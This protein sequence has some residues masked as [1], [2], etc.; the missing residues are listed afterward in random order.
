MSLGLKIASFIFVIA[1]AIFPAVGYENASGLPNHAF[2]WPKGRIKIAISPSLSAFGNGI[3][4]GSAVKEAILQSLQKWEDV[5]NVDFEI[6]STDVTTISPPGSVGDGVNVITIGNEPEN[7]QAFTDDSVNAPALTR[8]F[9]DVKGNINEADVVLNPYQ[10]YS[11]DR[12]VGTYDLET[13]FTHEIGHLLGLRHSNVPSATMNDGISKNNIGSFDA[14]PNTLALD[15]ITKIRGLYGTNPAILECCAVIKGKT[16]P[17]SNVWLQNPRT[18]VLVQMV[19]SNSEGIFE[20][21]GL[22]TGRYEVLVQPNASDDEQMSQ[23]SAAHLGIV[24]ASGATTYRVAP[25]QLG[26]TATF[27]LEYLSFAGQVAKRAVRVTRGQFYRIALAGKGLKSEMLFGSTNPK[28]SLIPLNLESRE[29]A[30]GIPS[31]G[32]EMIIDSSV[33]P[34]QYSLFAENQNGVRNYF[35]GSVWVE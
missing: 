29:F 11:S 10:Q 24:D 23:M 14:R 25:V 8:V 5:A 13:I 7:L 17:S 3:R 16:I 2:R 15:D 27:S 35:V 9:L 12:S 4:S 18:G 1:A 22:E 34:G 33:L 31:L 32:F 28:I 26:K 20:F 6:V 19:K 30:S 21:R